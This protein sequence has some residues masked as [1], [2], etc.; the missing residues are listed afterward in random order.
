MFSSSCI[1][2]RELPTCPVERAESQQRRRNSC[3]DF[4][5]SGLEP[6]V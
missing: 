4:S 6:K 1:L 3:T 5:A 2:I